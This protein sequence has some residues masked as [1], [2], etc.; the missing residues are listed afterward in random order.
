MPSQTTRM[1]ETHRSAVHYAWSMSRRLLG[2]AVPFVSLVLAG[3]TQAAPARVHDTWTETRL[4]A[5]WIGPAASGGSIRPLRIRTL[6]NGP[7]LIG[8]SW[9]SWTTTRAVGRGFIQACPGC[10]SDQGTPV[11]ITVDHP[12]E[13]GCGDP[14]ESI[15]HWFSRVQVKGP[16]GNHVYRVHQDGHPN[17]C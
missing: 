11:R 15:G 4:T 17:A 10:G 5:E 9:T 7:A 12:R 13:F 16:D 2:L 14:A 6:A 1:G 3:A 8:L